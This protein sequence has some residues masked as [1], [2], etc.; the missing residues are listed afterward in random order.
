MANKN[1]AQKGHFPWKYNALSKPGR[2][3]DLQTSCWCYPWWWEDLVTRWEIAPSKNSFSAEQNPAISLIPL[4]LCCSY[5]EGT[6]HTNIYLLAKSRIHFSP[7]KLSS[8]LWGGMTYSATQSC[9]SMDRCA[10]W[11]FCWR[12]AWDYS[13]QLFSAA[14]LSLKHSLSVFTQ[15]LPGQAHIG[16]KS[17]AGGQNHQR[18]LCTLRDIGQNTRQR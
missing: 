1:T 9:R 11:Q 6:K 5:K 17:F 4:S 18:R 15:Q 13:Y 10:T 16:E 14:L 8:S 12:Y 2:R 3:N 7:P